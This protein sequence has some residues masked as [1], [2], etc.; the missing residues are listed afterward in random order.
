MVAPYKSKETREYSRISF[1]T[2]DQR[3]RKRV[4]AAPRAK[5]PIKTPANGRVTPN[6][7]SPAN[8]K[9]RIMNQVER[10]DGI[11]VPFCVSLLFSNFAQRAKVEGFFMQLLYRS[12]KYSRSALWT[13]PRLLRFIAISN[14]RKRWTPNKLFH[15]RYPFTFVIINRVLIQPA[16]LIP[17]H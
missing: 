2:L 3:P 11:F 1:I 10:A 6:A 15:K 17:I 8:R 14:V 13:R 5:M 16:A 9:Y 7:A 4:T 12:L